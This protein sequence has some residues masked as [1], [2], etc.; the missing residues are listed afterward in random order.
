MILYNFLQVNI[1]KRNY[2]VLTC[3]LYK[4]SCEGLIVIVVVVVVVVVVVITLSMYSFYF[5]ILMSPYFFILI[6]DIFKEIVQGIPR[7]YH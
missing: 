1:T 3:I 4:N 5:S 6:T 2:V 7:D